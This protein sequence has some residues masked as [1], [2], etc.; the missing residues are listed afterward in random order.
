MNDVRVVDGDGAAVPAGTVGQI[1]VRGPQMMRE[2]WRDPEATAAVLAD[3]WLGAGDAD[4]PQIPLVEERDVP[5][6]PDDAFRVV[7][8]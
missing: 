3:G 5:E 2:Y 8:E 1:V 7:H 4:R 6:G